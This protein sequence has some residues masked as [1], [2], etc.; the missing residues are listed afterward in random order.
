MVIDINSKHYN[1]FFKH[2]FVRFDT[3]WNKM[4]PLLES[5]WTPSGPPSGQLSKPPSGPPFGP[6]S[7]PLPDCL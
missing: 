7:G 1:V 6:S 5:I 2:T 4:D 3:G